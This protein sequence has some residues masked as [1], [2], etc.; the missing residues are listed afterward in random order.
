MGISSDGLT[1]SFSSLGPELQ[2]SAT[3]AVV[4][5]VYLAHALVNRA[6]RLYW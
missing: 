3:P 2:V 4:D 5:A 6:R 1:I